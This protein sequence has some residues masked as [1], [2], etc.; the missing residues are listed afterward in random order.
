MKSTSRF[1][2]TVVEV[3]IVVVI[4][5]ILA[6]MAIPAF[7][8]VRD[9]RAK[10]NGTLAEKS[11]LDARFTYT[12]MA[13]VDGNPTTHITDKRTGKQFISIYNTGVA[14]LSK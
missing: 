5:G 1:G 12:P 11:E 10:E 13:R 6:A 7:E 8:K 2:F 9:K 14:D 3:M 4:I